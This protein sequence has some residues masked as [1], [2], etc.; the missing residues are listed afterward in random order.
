MA[1]KHD[2]GVN[3]GV[4]EVYRGV[5]PMCLFFPLERYSGRP[6][7]IHQLKSALQEGWA[8]FCFDFSRFGVCL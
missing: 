4:Y 1:Y 8:W 2:I 6:W 3:G 5:Y 7:A